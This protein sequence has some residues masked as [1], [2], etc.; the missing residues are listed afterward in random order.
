MSHILTTK[1]NYNMY[2]KII[3]QKIDDKA[4][5]SGFIANVFSV[6]FLGLAVT[7]VVAWWFAQSGLVLKLFSAEGGFNGLGYL[8]MFA[9]L[10]ISLVMQM[11][12]KKFSKLVLFLLF[13][14]YAV[15]MG[16]SLSFILLAF[17]GASIAITFGVTAATFGGMA[18]L[19][20]VTKTDLSKFGSIMMMGF[21]GIF[22]AGMINMFVGSE[23]LDYI[24][25][26]IGVL[27]FTGLTAYFMQNMKKI[28]NDPDIDANDKAKLAI[29]GGLQ[30]YI[31][32]INLFMT[33]LRFLG[34][35]N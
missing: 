11:A 8:V 22:L 28:A 3:D 30:L 29:I 17:T 9:P 14:G 24:I 4:A 20:Y 21:W 19:G 12:Y 31:L 35:R 13:A 33:L 18:L 34:D 15:L 1:N 2:E 27:V 32:F 5:A 7:A 6:M 16:M 26:M 23:G 25:S 10:G